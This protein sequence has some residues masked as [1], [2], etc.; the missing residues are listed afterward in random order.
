[1]PSCTW[2]T[3]PLPVRAQLDRL[4][5]AILDVTRL[6]CLGIYL[7]GS[8]A[9]GCFNP[10]RSDL[11]LLVVCQ[12]PLP[13]ASFPILLKNFLDLSLRPRPV[14]ISFLNSAGLHPW[15]HP[16][17]F[18]LHYSEDWRPRVQAML[19]DGS[20]QA[21]Y[22]RPKVDSDLAAH[23]TITLRRGVTL[24]GQPPAQVLPSIPAQDYRASILEDLQWAGERFT[25]FPAYAILNFCRIWAF[26]DEG[27]VFSKLEGA[28]WA[29]P[30]LS[31]ADRILVQQALDFYQSDSPAI[32][33][34]SPDLETRF[35]NLLRNLPI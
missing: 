17:P 13:A 22:A 19:A 29:L 3:C 35:S 26:L 14:E 12:S 6:D 20:W 28:L 10:Q 1:M 21:E 8:L 33:P 15:R 7:H 11:D 27:C 2:E 23:I 32:F 31:P 9:L 24:W 4:V 25:Q 16:A 5:S 34:S 18:D 30:R